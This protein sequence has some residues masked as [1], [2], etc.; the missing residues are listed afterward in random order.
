MIGLYIL[1]DKVVCMIGSV[2]M[3]ATIAPMIDPQMISRGQCTP[4]V[5]RETSI[6]RAKPRKIRQKMI[7]FLSPVLYPNI[8]TAIAIVIPTAA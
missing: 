6:I 8:S 5:I 4:I 7:V 1:S 2:M 3:K